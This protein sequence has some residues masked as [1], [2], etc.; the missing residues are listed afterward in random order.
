MALRQVANGRD[1]YTPF[2]YE[3]KL[4]CSAYGEAPK[5]DG[6]IK[7]GIFHTTIRAINTLRT[8]NGRLRKA[9]RSVPM[10]PDTFIG[11]HAE[12]SRA[13]GKREATKTFRY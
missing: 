7:M 9:D 5:W 1:V 13:R 10:L 12:N 3:Y 6:A 11:E 2:R 4:A 8:G